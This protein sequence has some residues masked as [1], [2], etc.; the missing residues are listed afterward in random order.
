MGDL[1]DEPSNKSLNNILGASKPGSGN[2]V[3]WNMMYPEFQK[4]NGSYFFRGEWNML[5]NIV[6]STALA[7]GN[8]IDIAGKQGYVFR[9]KWMITRDRNGNEMPFRTFSG[10]EYLGGISDHLPVYIRLTGTGR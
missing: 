7:D 6:V 3:L 1:N 5:D 10:Q 4:K 9:E 2:S 8:G